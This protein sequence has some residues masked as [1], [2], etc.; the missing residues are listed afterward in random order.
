M[1]QLQTK[2]IKVIFKMPS[3]GS[4]VGEEKEG[5]LFKL[6]IMFCDNFQESKNNIFREDIMF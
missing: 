1:Q 6:F 4:L 2:I 3:F 5:L